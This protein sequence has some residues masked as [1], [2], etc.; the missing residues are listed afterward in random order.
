[1][2]SLP[3]PR[4]V[5]DPAIA[6]VLR[7]S[8]RDV[9]G[10]SPA[11]RPGA[12]RQSRPAFRPLP[13]LSFPGHHPTFRASHPRAV[14]R[15]LGGGYGGA[16][17]ARNGVG[18]LRRLPPPPRARRRS[19]SDHAKCGGVSITDSVFRLCGNALSPMGNWGFWPLI[20]S[21]TNARGCTLD[22][23]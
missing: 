21:P 7:P 9:V 13:P 2:K 15:L 20:F 4:D 12:D 16:K 6:A 19:D 22:H 3:L 14:D 10:D 23:F 5:E 18:G 8:V 1:M 17:T 11:R